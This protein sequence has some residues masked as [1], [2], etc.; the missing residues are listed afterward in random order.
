MMMCKIVFIL[1]TLQY[2]AIFDDIRALQNNYSNRYT[3][4]YI[5][6]KKMNTFLYILGTI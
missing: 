1:V 4:K 2:Y 5:D 3:Y 6:F